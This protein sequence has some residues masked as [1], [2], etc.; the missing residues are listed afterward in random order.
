MKGNQGQLPL[1]R[2][3][4]LRNHREDPR[5]RAPCPVWWLMCPGRQP[6][7]AHPGP[8]GFSYCLELLRYLFG[9]V[10]YQY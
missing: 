10:W 5:L 9:M 4:K 7:S 3:S 2:A 8:P 6:G 1:D